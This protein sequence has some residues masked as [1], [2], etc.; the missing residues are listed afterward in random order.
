MVN[1][2]EQDLKNQM[3]ELGPAAELTLGAPGP[4][5][6]TN[7]GGSRPLVHF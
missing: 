2:E 6:E 7:P 5:L 3:A 4:N 1:V